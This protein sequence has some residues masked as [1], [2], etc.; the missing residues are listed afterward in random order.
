MRDGTGVSKLGGVKIDMNLKGRG[1]GI[2]KLLRQNDWDI[3][4]YLKME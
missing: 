3:I 2:T 4:F 1:I